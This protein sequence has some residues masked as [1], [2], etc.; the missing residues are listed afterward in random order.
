MGF[1][2]GGVPKVVQCGVS[3]SRGFQGGPVCGF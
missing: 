2:S 3:E 1:L